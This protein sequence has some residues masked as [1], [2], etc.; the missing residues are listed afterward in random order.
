[1]GGGG[2]AAA[3]A[4]VVV[5]EEEG[6]YPS[7]L[8]ELKYGISIKVGTLLHETNIASERCMAPIPP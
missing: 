7:I 3:A 6:V 4:V 8:I 2:A 1:M 5:V